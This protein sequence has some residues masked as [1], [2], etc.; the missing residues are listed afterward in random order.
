MFWQFAKHVAYSKKIYL[1][2]ICNTFNR[3]ILKE[4]LKNENAA[5]IYSPS[6]HPWYACVS[7]Y[8]IK[9]FG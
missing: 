8:N 3:T 6:G 5:V 7:Q 1:W 9:E 2:P 4:L